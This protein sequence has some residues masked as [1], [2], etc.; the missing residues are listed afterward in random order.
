M[1]GEPPFTPQIVIPG[2]ASGG[3]RAVWVSEVP[4]QHMNISLF[5]Q[6]F[7]FCFFLLKLYKLGMIKIAPHVTSN[8]T[9]II[10]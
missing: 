6:C 3:V 9:T 2:C 5:F 1:G 10:Q 8:Q 7:L 4:P